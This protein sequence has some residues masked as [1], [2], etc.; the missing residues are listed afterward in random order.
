MCYGSV[1]ANNY[2]AG[3]YI[4]YQTFKGDPYILKAYQE[5]YKRQPNAWELNI[6][7]Y[8][9]GSW[10]SYDYIKKYIQDFQTYMQRQ[11]VKFAFGTTKNKAQVVV[12]LIVNNQLIAADVISIGGGAIVAQG[13]SSVLAQGGAK[14]A[15]KGG[16]SFKI[17][18]DIAGFS[19]GSGAD[20]PPK[21]TQRFLTSGPGA[22]IVK[23]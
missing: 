10:A 16:S 7:N 4:V 19:F 21:G 22:L 8:N 9:N 11:N 18:K 17:T 1:N 6:F 2:L 14:V 23:K 15:I 13:G 20:A 12:G 3:N 5:L